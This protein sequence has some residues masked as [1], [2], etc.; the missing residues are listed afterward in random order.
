LNK[1]VI[2][3]TQSGIIKYMEAMAQVMAEAALA[4]EQAIGDSPYYAIDKWVDVVRKRARELV[5]EKKDTTKK[6]EKGVTIDQEK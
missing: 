1:S 6:I 3:D 2:A 4:S 5:R